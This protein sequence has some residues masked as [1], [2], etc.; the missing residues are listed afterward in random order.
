VR[1]ALFGLLLPVRL[2]VDAHDLC[3]VHEAIDQRHNTSGVD[4]TFTVPPSY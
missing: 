4:D 3:A 1:S 2:A